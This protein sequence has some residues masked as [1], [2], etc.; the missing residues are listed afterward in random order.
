MEQETRKSGSF[1][2]TALAVLVLLVAGWLLLGFI[3]HILS[4]LLSTVILVVAVIAA[5]WAL[6]IIL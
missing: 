1:G 4:V 2:R 3:G 5:I 6:K